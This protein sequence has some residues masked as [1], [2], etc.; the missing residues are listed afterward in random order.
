VILIGNENP[1]EIMGNGTKIEPIVEMG[2]GKDPDENGNDLIPIENTSHQWRTTLLI[3]LIRMIWVCRE[4]NCQ[5]IHQYEDCWRRGLNGLLAREPYRSPTTV[6][7]RLPSSLCATASLIISQWACLHS[8]SQP[9]V[10]M[11]SGALIWPW[12]NKLVSKKTSTLL[13][14]K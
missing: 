6:Q 5:S 4:K 2:M 9:V 12:F 1:I 14:L 7:G 13:F 11:R 3:Y 10:C 8:S